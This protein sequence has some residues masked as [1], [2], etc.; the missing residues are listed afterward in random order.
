[1]RHNYE[2]LRAV[3]K[4][5]VDAGHS[6]DYVATALNMS[7]TPTVSGRGRWAVGNVQ[8]ACDALGIPHPKYRPAM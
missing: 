4:A 1:M 3:M 8:R 6:A 5:L 2:P 7:K